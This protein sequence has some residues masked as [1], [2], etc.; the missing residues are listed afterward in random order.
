MSKEAATAALANLVGAPVPTTASNPSLSGSPG[1]QAV[2]APK[3]ESVA[4]KAPELDS[5]RINHLLKKEQ[6]LQRQREI[7]KKERETLLSEKHTWD[8]QR[9]VLSEF[10]ALKSKDPVAALRLAGFS[11][12]DLITFANAQADTRSPEERARA[13]AADEIKKFQDGQKTE[14]DKAQTERNTQVLTQFRNDITKVVGANKDKYEYCNHNGPLAQE[15][16]YD[17]V[18]AVLAESGEVISIAEA[19]DLVET[20]YE[21]TDKAMASLKK[22]GPKSSVDAP[23]PVS[24]PK[25]TRTVS[26]QGVP[27][28]VAASVS[29]TTSIPK[30]ETRSQKRERLMQKLAGG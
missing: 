17:T 20:Y 2:E 15:L 23:A 26:G 29:S 10:Q 14:A 18:A 22:R 25:N 4:P 24:T 1:L 3:A 30:A 21:D 8:E 7:N 28:K 12:Q 16:I 6:E 13:A 5:T 11:E 9:K 19:A 27:A